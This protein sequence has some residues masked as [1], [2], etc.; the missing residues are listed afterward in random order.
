MADIKEVKEVKEAVKKT[1]VDK[2][3]PVCQQLKPEQQKGSKRQ[4]QPMQKRTSVMNT[5][6]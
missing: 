1:V 4:G 5:S 3:K 2:S 6:L